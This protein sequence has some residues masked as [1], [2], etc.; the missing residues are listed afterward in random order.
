[1]LKRGYT[2]GFDPQL[3]NIIKRRKRKRARLMRRRTALT[4]RRYR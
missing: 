3:P 1:M 2:P 4:R